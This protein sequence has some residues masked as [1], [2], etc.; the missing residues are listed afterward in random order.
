MAGLLFKKV[1]FWISLSA[2]LLAAACSTGSWW[3]CKPTSQM[4]P[5][6]LEEQ[7]PEFWPMWKH[8]HED[9]L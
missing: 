1:M 3:K 6:E 2:V 8:M 9:R 4:T 5:A 7:D